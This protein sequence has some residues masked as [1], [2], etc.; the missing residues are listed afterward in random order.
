M[1]T[2]Y[3]ALPDRHMQHKGRRKF[4]Q[5]GCGTVSPEVGAWDAISVVGSRVSGFRL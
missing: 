2:H 3:G 4:D 5:T 1:G